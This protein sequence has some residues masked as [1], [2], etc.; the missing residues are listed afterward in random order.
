M[1]AT[2]KQRQHGILGGGGGGGGEGGGVDMTN[3]SLIKQLTAN[4]SIRSTLNMH[5]RDKNR[6]AE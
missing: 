2:P 4:H 1:P 5:A 6:L 3:Q